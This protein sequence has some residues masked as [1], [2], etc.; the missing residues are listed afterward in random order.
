MTCRA[1]NGAGAAVILDGSETYAHGPRFESRVRARRTVILPVV[2]FVV[3]IIVALAGCTT[4]RTRRGYLR[5]NA[6]RFDEPPARPVIVLP[7]FGVS[8]LF[9]PVT[10]RFVWGTAHTMMQRRYAD[11]LDLQSGDRLV[12]RGF[13]GSRGPINI[14]WQLTEA[15]R[16]YG[17]YTRD[18]DLY[19]FAYDWRRS[20]RENA[21]ELAKFVDD[22]RRAHGGAKVDIVTHSAGALVGLAYVKLIAPDTVE[23]L[24]L[25]APTQRGVADVFRL[26]VRGEHFLRRSF[27]T[28]MATTWASTY[29]LLPEEGRFLVDEQ[30]R[31]VT[32]DAW[33]AASWPFPIDGEALARA[34]RF[35]DELRDAP[36]PADVQLTVIAG[37]CVPTARRV[38]ARG[39][40]TY[41]FYRDELREDERALAAMLFEPGDGTVPVSSATAGREALLFC[42]GH[43][44]IA[45]DPNV[46]RALIR[47]LRPDTLR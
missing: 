25:V 31:E 23:H 36:V 8:R 6:A 33:D 11:D 18:R 35:R 47:I 30:G 9:D 1:D 39:D 42:D 2:L 19:A 29:E 15:L 3:L 28:E 12:P 14:A 32:F 24:V 27:T 4:D 26:F 16:K 37:D 44:G 21:Q 43:Q 17:G 46:H 13:V 45:S 5:E 40:R 20:A 41:A 7:G 38:L 34:R 10:G 22:V